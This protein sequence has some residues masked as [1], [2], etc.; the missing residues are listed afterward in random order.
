M[1][2]LSFLDTLLAGLADAGCVL[3]V[4]AACLQ[5]AWHQNAC[6]QKAST[7]PENRA[8]TGEGG[9]EGD[10]HDQPAHSPCWWKEVC[11]PLGAA[12]IFAWHWHGAGEGLV[13]WLSL[14]APCMLAAAL[15]LLLGL[16]R[17]RHV[18]ALQNLSLLLFVPAVALLVFA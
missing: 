11:L 14:L 4:F 10:G 17:E 7:A 3:L 12:Y 15:C 16:A 5:L 1:T 18:R 8:R 9:D 6:R 2:I 13:L